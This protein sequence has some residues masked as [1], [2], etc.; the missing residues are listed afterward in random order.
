MTSTIHSAALALACAAG[1]LLA[2]PA[3]AQDYPSRPITIVVPYGPGSYTDNVVRPV[4]VALQKV[5]GQ[6]VV[7][8]NKAGAN[9]IVGTQF[10]ARAK[11]DGYTL[12]A[13]STTTLAAN[14]GLYKSLPYDVRK[15]F[16][17]IGG[18]ASTSMMFMVRAD[19]PAKNLKDFLAYAAKQPTPM[20]LAYGS[21]SAQ[22]AV[23]LLAKE[24]GVKFT[25]IGY[26]GTPQA[27]TDL[28]GGQV[29]AAIVDVANGVPQIRAGKLHA[30]AISGTSRSVAAPEVPT[31]AESWPGTQLV[32]W[33]GLVAPVGTPAAIVDK[34]SA[35][36]ATALA[37]PEIRQQF[38]TLSTELEPTSGPELGRRMQRDHVQ[39]LDL[40][41]AAGIQPE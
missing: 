20:P 34:L 2:T 24:S 25:G 27:I 9:G 41:K 8:D 16:V 35:A 6:T 40:I 39:W 15:D 38:V 18:L 3:G 28:I 1:A 30:L 13:G 32:T 14:D 26:K 17:P 5:L 23:A 11:P 37:T 36:L 22:V 29:P 12:L 4:A 10:G 21:S 7:V 33:V 19:F 31:L